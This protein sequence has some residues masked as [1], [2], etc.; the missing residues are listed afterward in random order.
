MELVIAFLLFLILLAIA[1]GI[2]E[3]LFQIVWFVVKAAVVVA[4]IVVG[5]FWLLAALG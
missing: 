1:P 4:V 3:C 2:V 5:G